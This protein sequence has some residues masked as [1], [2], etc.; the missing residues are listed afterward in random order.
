MMPMP[1]RCSQLKTILPLP[2]A[3]VS[4]GTYDE[5]QPD[6]DLGV[7]ADLSAKH[8]S[9]LK[10]MDYKL[11]MKRPGWRSSPDQAST[12][13]QDNIKNTEEDFIHHEGSENFQKEDEIHVETR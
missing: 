3:N 10:M 12:Q 4:I 1:S 13:G 2:D 9:Q 6:E 5:W 11:K 7:V 8:L